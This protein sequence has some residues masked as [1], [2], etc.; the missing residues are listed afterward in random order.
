MGK[1]LFGGAQ[2]SGEYML[3]SMGAPLLEVLVVNRS[4][5]SAGPAYVAKDA[6]LPHEQGVQLMLGLVQ[7]ALYAYVA[8]LGLTL[9]SACWYP[10]VGQWPIIFAPAFSK[11]LHTQASSQ[12]A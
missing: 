7:Y 9:D 3:L 8:F 6:S 12:V 11:C 5:I 4:L 2:A 1:L 10:S